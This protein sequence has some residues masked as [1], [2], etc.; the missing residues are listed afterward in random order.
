MAGVLRA[1]NGRTDGD[2]LGWWW[3]DTLRQHVFR[4]PSV[5]NFYP[6]DYPVPGTGLVG[7]AFGIHNANGALQRI[8]YVN[9]LV[10]WGGSQPNGSVPDAIGTK[11]DLSPFDADAE[12]P[13]R[14]V[15]RLSRLALGQALPPQARSQVIN[16]VAAFNPTRDNS[17][18]RN[19]VK[20]AAYLVFSA[21]QYHV[22]R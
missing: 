13:A 9:Y 7:P 19:R 17:H 5:F 20:T 6:P 14:L 11:V 10:N 16:A 3:G 1:L 22:I 4:A 18:L 15:D 2:A 8:N 21:P 12:D